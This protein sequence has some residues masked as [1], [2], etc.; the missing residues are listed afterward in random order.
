MIEL[1]KPFWMGVIKWGAIVGGIL[2]VLFKVRQ[3]GKDAV[4]NENIKET[5]EGVKVRDKIK[6]NIVTADDVERKRLR[7]K[8]NRD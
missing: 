3:S 4:Q 1:L 5:L 6:D 8:W 2:L 7:K